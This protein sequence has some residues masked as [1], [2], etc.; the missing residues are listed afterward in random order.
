MPL[1]VRALLVERGRLQ[2]WIS[3]KFA[4]KFRIR[5]T[6][7][8]D[9]PGS[10]FWRPGPRDSAQT[11]MTLSRDLTCAAPSRL[12]QR[13]PYLDQELVEFLTSIPFDQLLRPGCRRYLMRRALAHL[14]PPEVRERKT[15][16]SASR[17]YPL[18]LQKHWWRVEHALYRPLSSSLGY[19]ERDGLYEDLD[20]LRN[21]IV[22][23]HL[24]RLLK[25]LSLE[26]WLRDVQKRGIVNIPPLS[27]QKP[28]FG[29]LV[30]PQ[31]GELSCSRPQAGRF[32]KRPVGRHCG[33]CVPCII[34]RASLYAVGLDSEERV[35]DVLSSGIRANEAAGYDKRAFLMA[36][37]RLRDMSPLQ[38]TSEIMSAGP[39]NTA[40]VGALTGVFTRGMNEVEQFL[41]QTS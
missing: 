6:Q 1:R 9:L 25:A 35:I 20:Q 14:L 7:L 5:D 40:E 27:A 34:R 36:I 15:K 19:I 30:Q 13:Y 33:Y 4:K 29:R 10:W 18:T 31:P 3:T 21:G 17:C 16:V 12:E 22:P 41:R 32:H 23:L 8:E 37:A 38:I 2:P 26:L 11:I 28:L 24:V 39:L